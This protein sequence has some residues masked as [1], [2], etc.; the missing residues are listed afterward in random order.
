MTRRLTPAALERW[1]LAP[2]T[3]IEEVLHDP[4]TGSPYRLLPAERAFLDFA[5]RTGDD[6]K[7]LYPE[8][9][10]SAGKK[11]GKT[12]FAAL[13]VLTT[14]LLFGGR[15][16][17]AICAAN[18]LEQS[19]GRVFEAV[20]KI[21]ECS[22]LLKRESKITAEKISFPVIGAT[23]A[24]IPHDF[25]GAAGGNPTISSFDELWAFRAERSRRLWDEMVPPP[26]RK[27]AL[28]LTTTYAGYTGESVLLEELLK[29]GTAQPLVGKDLYAGDGILCFLT[30]EPIAPWQTQSWLGQM[31]QQLRANA[32]IRMIEN[33]FVTTEST[34]CDMDWFD[35]CVD[36]TLR[37]EL[38]GGAMMPVW[39]GVDASVKHDSSAV[40]AVT[41]D[42]K[43]K[44]VRLVNHRVFQP[45]PDKPLDFEATIESTVREFARRFTVRSV[46]YDPYQMA[47]V[48]QRLQAS[49]I[50]MREYPQSVPALTAMGSNL[51]E[52][53]KSGSLVVYPDDALRLAI[54]RT[55]SL[56]TPRG[57]RLAKE[58][59]S[60]KIDV[61]IAL[62]MASLHAVEQATRPL[63]LLG[64]GGKVFSSTGATIADSVSH[65]F[66]RF[67]SKP[68]LTEND[69]LHQA[70]LRQ[71][72]ME[73]K[74]RI[75]PPSNDAVA[76]LRAQAPARA[77]PGICNFH[78]K[79]LGGSTGR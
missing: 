37:P 58:K 56:E 35:R 11:S 19:V 44:R 66:D 62:A 15:H 73:M 75:E 51:Y 28:R 59:T 53:I 46:H 30:H 2:A 63:Q 20:R 72:H 18:D 40:V 3:F 7:L 48:A 52:L 8:Q 38:M 74:A 25:A 21:V 61:V 9:V 71:Q 39:V 43:T 22:P 47:A 12:T 14:V 69:K 13:H 16:P 78:G 60:H 4:E 70:N 31:R 32:F 54:S 79:L 55:I 1:R 76:E 29:R 17:E 68:E 50:R 45:T 67:R 64:L 57:I 77:A 26:T 6:G 41:Y 49:G 33:K 42:D 24:A 10:Y 65:H 34:F 27:I 5:F 36:P 23:I